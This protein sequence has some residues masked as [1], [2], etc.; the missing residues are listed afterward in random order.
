MNSLIATKDS[1]T[2]LNKSRPNLILRS[3]TEHLF[4][5][6]RPNK[7]D[8]FC[9]S[10]TTTN[11]IRAQDDY[12][13][14][15][16]TFPTWRFCWTLR[17]IRIPTLYTRIKESLKAK[18]VVF[19]GNLEPSDVT[20]QQLMDEMMRNGKF[21]NGLSVKDLKRHLEIM[22]SLETFGSS[23]TSQQASSMQQSYVT[24]EAKIIVIGVVSKSL[25]EWLSITKE[26]AAH[27]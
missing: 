25:R 27:M 9:L 2:T 5:K 22:V 19:K 23:S 10:A 4:P 12:T 3:K 15:K 16:L 18:R 26:I 1:N 24:K 7:N 14:R 13:K 21:V 11:T 17:A 20:E 8:S 6:T